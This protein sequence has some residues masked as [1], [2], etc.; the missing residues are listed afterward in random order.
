MLV[1]LYP[2]NSNHYKNNSLVDGLVLNTAN[3]EREREREREREISGIV[4]YYS[5]EMAYLDI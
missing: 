2:Y 5:F 3:Y 4:Y 1:F